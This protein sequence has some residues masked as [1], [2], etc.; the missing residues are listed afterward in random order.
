M[1][2]QIVNFIDNIFQYYIMARLILYYFIH[3]IYFEFSLNFKE[4]LTHQ[5]SVFYKLKLFLNL[6][7]NLTVKFFQLLLENFY[8][9][10]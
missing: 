10:I 3:I 1:H 6:N 8:K 5:K 7:M 2:Y 4:H 9:F